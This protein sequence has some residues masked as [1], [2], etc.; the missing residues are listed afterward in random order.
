MAW[1]KSEGGGRRSFAP[2]PLWKERGRGAERERAR[3]LLLVLEGCA[4]ASGRRAQG[5]R[6]GGRHRWSK[7][8]QRRGG[9]K[10]CRKHSKDRLKGGDG[11]RHSR[12]EER[13]SLSL[14]Y[15]A[16]MKRRR[17]GERLGEGSGPG[18]EFGPQGF[19]G[20]EVDFYWEIRFGEKKKSLEMEFEYFWSRANIW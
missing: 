1:R 19:E 11:D 2:L 20:G 9:F 4:W 17:R 7:I 18:K 13:E 14:G 10:P 5:Q 3:A 16:R 15:G 8:E 6:L 12:R